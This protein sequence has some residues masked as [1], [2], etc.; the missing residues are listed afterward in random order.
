[1]KT[2]NYIFDVEMII[3][4]KVQVIGN[5]SVNV[6]SHRIFRGICLSDVYNLIRN[7]SVPENEDVKIT[8]NIRGVNY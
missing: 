2:K 3:D 6:S 4:H 7:N 1:M 5:E 8:F